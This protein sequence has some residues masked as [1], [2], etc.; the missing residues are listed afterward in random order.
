[1]VFRVGEIWAIK[2]HQRVKEIHASHPGVPRRRK[3]RRRYH[4]A[5][6]HQAD[7]HR[8]LEPPAK[9]RAALASRLIQRLEKEKQELSPE[10]WEKA[11]GEEAGV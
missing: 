11:W 8:G 6:D 1:M 9:N 10:E 2:G 4:G 3:R 5:R 7:R